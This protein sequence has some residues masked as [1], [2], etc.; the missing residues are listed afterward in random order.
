MTYMTRKAVIYNTHT[1]TVFKWYALL[2]GNLCQWQQVRLLNV[3]Y[4]SA[5]VVQDLK[6]GVPIGLSF[7]TNKPFVCRAELY[8]KKKKLLLQKGTNWDHCRQI[9]EVMEVMMSGSWN[10]SVKVN[11]V[12]YFMKATGMSTIYSCFDW[13]LCIPRKAQ[14]VVPVLLLET[15]FLSLN[16]C[17]N[18]AHFMHVLERNL[19]CVCI[20]LVFLFRMLL[21]IH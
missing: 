6:D 16:K 4:N 15:C 13:C 21:F 3:I 9:V 18:A 1:H 8:R 5:D 17:Q 10:F 2:A 11:D 20:R 19:L 7:V 14:P 12:W